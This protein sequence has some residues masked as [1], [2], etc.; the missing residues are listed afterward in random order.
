MWLRCVA[1]AGWLDSIL[2]GAVARRGPGGGQA[3]LP[4]LLGAAH[5]PHGPHPDQQGPGRGL[6]GPPHCRPDG[7]RLHGQ[8]VPPHFTSGTDSFRQGLIHLGMLVLQ[9]FLLPVCGRQWAHASLS[10][11]FSECT[12]HAYIFCHSC[13]ISRNHVMPCNITHVTNPVLAQM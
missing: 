8:A 1:T 2:G 11:S 13:S 7:Q 10:T 6:A 4:C 3:D 12:E 5:L 9:P